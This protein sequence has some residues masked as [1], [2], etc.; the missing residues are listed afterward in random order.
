MKSACPLLA[1]SIAAAVAGCA[2]PVY[3]PVQPKLSSAVPARSDASPVILLQPVVAGKPFDE[4]VSDNVRGAMWNPDESGQIGFTQ[5]YA[6]TLAKQGPQIALMASAPANVGIGMAASGQSGFNVSSRIMVPYGRYITA[7]LREL[8]A[9]SA[10]NATLCLDQQC[11]QSKPQ[12]GHATP[13]VTV[14]FTQL[15]VAE[16]KTNTLTLVV[17]GT[18]TVD[19]DGRTRTIPIRHSIVERSITSE[20]MWHSAYLRVMNAA[21]NEITSSVAQ[22][23]LAAAEAPAPAGT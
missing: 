22:Q 11:V 9:Q 14:R 18:A 21:A 5:N 2:A 16:N 10:P 15:S 19:Q 8:M 3:Q 4:I 13:L 20:G 6:D 12:A 7:N 23:V 17:E 1:L